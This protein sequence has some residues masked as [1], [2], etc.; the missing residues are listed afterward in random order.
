MRA[1]VVIKSG[2]VFEGEL[3][4]SE[5]GTCRLEDCSNIRK[6]QSGGFGGLT[7]S[8][9]TSGATLDPC[10][11][12]TFHLDQMILRVPTPDGWADA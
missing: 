6:W 10:E 4:E 12:V 3:L 5:D 7:K 11:P 2:W 1:I 9:T 8:A